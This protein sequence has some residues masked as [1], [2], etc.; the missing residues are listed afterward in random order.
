V[1]RRPDLLSRLK[2][3]FSAAPNLTRIPAGLCRDDGMAQ[4]RDPPRQLSGVIEEL[5]VNYHCFGAL[6][7][8]SDHTHS[9]RK[10]GGLNKWQFENK[11]APL[12][13]E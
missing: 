10:A 2:L 5:R 6:T 3:E 11:S 4:V 7:A 8:D 12:D 13:S 1:G 9:L